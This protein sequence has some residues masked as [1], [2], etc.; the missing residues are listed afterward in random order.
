MDQ[1]IWK[2]IEDYNGLYQISSFGR[3]KSLRQ[4]IIMKL[5]P[6]EKGYLKI[7]LRKNKKVKTFKVHR[8][9][10]KAFIP[11]T[12]NKSEINHINHIRNDNRVSNLEWTNHADNMIGVKCGCKG[13]NGKKVAL[14]VLWVK[15]IKKIIKIILLLHYK[16]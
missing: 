1:E 8:L 12:D 9:V 4:N 3:V 16:K 7:N 11:N 14:F 2:D 13:N 6:T 15:K 10:A 5:S